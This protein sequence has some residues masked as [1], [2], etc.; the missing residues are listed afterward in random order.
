MSIDVVDPLPYEPAAGWDEMVAPGAGVRAHWGYLHEALSAL[1]PSELERRRR[2]VDR[3]LHDD[4]ATYAV[5]GE[6]VPRRWEV[7]PVPLLIS[8]EEW[9]SIERGIAQRAD[10]LDLVLADLY[11]PR[12]L[13]R[14]GLLPPELVFGHPGFLRPTVGQ[15][16]PGGR[17]L[18]LHSADLSRDTEGRWTVL[19]DRTQA[20]SGAGYALENRFV[21]TR[22]FPSIFRD[23]HVHRLAPYFRAMRGAMG[24]LAD[25]S[26]DRP[27]TVILTPGPWNETYFEHAFLASYL[28]Y[29]LVQ[30]SDL[31]VRGGRVWLRSVGA[32][33]PVDV[34]VRRVDDDW[35]DPV[36]LRPE[37]S[38]GV[39]GLVELARRGAIGL[40]NPLGSGVV[41]HPGLAAFLP[42]LARE[43][44]GQDLHLPSLPTYWCGDHAARRHVVGDL[45]R[46][47]I[48][49]VRRGRERL[50]VGAELSEDERMALVRRIEANPHRFAA[51][52]VPPAATA[53]CLVEGRLAPRATVLRTFA[54]AR[55]GSWALLPG[56]L[57]R[58]LPDG[59]SPLSLVS[60]PGKDTWVLASEP[61]STLSLVAGA[62]GRVAA[63]DPAHA[64][65]ARVAEN[66]FWL[67][68]YAE[69]AEAVTRLTRVIL[70]R[71]NDTAG[72]WNPTATT[73][74]V[75]LLEALTDVSA[76][77]GSGFVGSEAVERLAAPD[78]TLVRLLADPSEVGSLAYD[79]AALLDAAV[80]VRDQLSLDT[81]LVLN[82]L[83]EDLA[84]VAGGDPSDPLAG[85]RAG[86]GGIMKSLLALAGLVNE[87]MVRDPGWR[88]LD[89]GRRLERAQLLVR[90]LRST[91]VPVRDEHVD[92]LVYESLLSAA[93]SI[94]TYRRRYQ[95]TYEPAAILELLLG[96]EANPRSVAYQ[97]GQLVTS[98]ADLPRALP[99]RRSEEEKAALAAATLVAVAEP[100]DLAAPSSEHGRRVALASM[101][102]ELDAAL[103]RVGATLATAHFPPLP[104][105]Q[106]LLGPLGSW[107]GQE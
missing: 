37:S 48:R 100:D 30:G 90:L 27:L 10:L 44:L 74:L 73:A 102:D 7:D 45:D 86:L 28:G 16:V 53:P 106:L 61:E 13:I 26:V 12:T 67:G 93:E 56:G 50:H 17:H 77:Y 70:D 65:S 41:E 91:L 79:L 55:D 20:P 85:A 105:R 22:V 107:E 94:V 42:S 81:W 66:L 95:S 40:A 69:R 89:A 43:L 103:D 92:A 46:F 52:E 101:L 19:S 62:E 97:L 1:G 96:D 34:I 14:R 4:G 88:F 80:A 64:I 57:T 8:S 54:V 72:R 29:P 63:M 21:M 9:G 31:E 33:E 49:S 98:V 18:L 32:H 3:L 38:L 6:P 15:D 24:A 71:R 23:A 60:G 75:A 5:P 2:Q 51:Q 78:A 83:E 82:S 36:E 47:V 11:G 87:S 35:C 25:R 68:R 99:N 58:T 104:D 84:V 39:P 59:A 76:T